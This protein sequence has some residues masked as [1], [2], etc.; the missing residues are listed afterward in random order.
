MRGVVRVGCGCQ[1]GA[2]VGSRR[3]GASCGIARLGAVDEEMVQP[4]NGGVQVE[5]F[6]DA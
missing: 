5:M 6:E 4:L 2:G 3:V 1:S